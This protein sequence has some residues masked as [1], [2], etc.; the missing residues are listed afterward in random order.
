MMRA[1][2]IAFA[3][4]CAPTVIH[5]WTTLP[6]HTRFHLP[7]IQRPSSSFAVSR[8]RRSTFLSATVLLTDLPSSSILLAEESWRQYVPL[9][10]SVLVIF[11]ILL[12]SPLLNLI[13]APM[14]RQAEGDSTDTKDGMFGATSQKQPRVNPKER[15]DSEQ[16]AQQALDKARNSLELRQY[17]DAQK[18]DW[19]RMEEIRKKM[20]Q[21]MADLDKTLAEKRQQLEE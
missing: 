4:A 19:D 8:R 15:I 6:S 17:L 3:L 1:S 2:T 20:D 11:D 12:G 14:K 16:V 10:V 13:V 21:D 9:A 7:E 18:T 5:S